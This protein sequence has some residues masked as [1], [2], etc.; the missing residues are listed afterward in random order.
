MPVTPQ[1]A[2]APPPG[3]FFGQQ[4]ALNCEPSDPFILMAHPGSAQVV[5]DGLDGPTWIPALAPLY[6]TPGVNLVQIKRKGHTN[7]DMYREALAHARTKGFVPVDPT[8]VQVVAAEHLPEGAVPGPY[9]RA[10][11]TFDRRTQLEGTLYKEVWYTRMASRSP[12]DPPRWKFDRAAYNRWVVALLEAGIIPGPDE[13]A[14]QE[15]LAHAQTWAD[16][17][18]NIDDPAKRADR[19]KGEAEHV[20]KLKAAR[21]VDPNAPKPAPKSRSK[22]ASA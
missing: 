4:A 14:R 16:R 20:D 17:Q 13:F 8:A 1:H 22:R 10:Y 15:Y 5:T 9:M 12:T 3:G 21:V 11:P 6:I 19:V 18:H 7:E 2:T